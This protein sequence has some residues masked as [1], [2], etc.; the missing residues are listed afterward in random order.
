L[1]APAEATVP[2]PKKNG[3][4]WPRVLREIKPN[5]PPEAMRAKLEGAVDMEIIVLPDGTVRDVRVTKGLELGL[6]EA[7]VAAAHYWLFVPGQKD[8]KPVPTKVG[9]VLEF[10]LR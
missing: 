2:E 1:A 3:V 6:T 9:L 5:Y 4:S 8:G 10:R 7:A